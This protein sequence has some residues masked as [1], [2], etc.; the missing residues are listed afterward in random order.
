MP[1]YGGSGYDHIYLP[2]YLLKEGMY[3]SQAGRRNKYAQRAAA[4]RRIQ[5]GYRRYRRTTGNAD[6]R[7]LTS[8]LRSHRKA[9]PYQI[10]PSSG[11]TVTFWRKCEVNLT[12][13]QL[14]GFQLA[15]NNV[16]FGFSLR[17]VFGFINGVFAINTSVPNVSEFQALFDYYRISAV[18][19]QM[20]FTKNVSETSGLNIGLPVM[21]LANDFDDIAETMTRDSMNERV[22]CRHVQFSAYNENGINHYIKPKPDTVIVQTDPTTG[23]ESASNSGVVFGSQWIDTAQSN[24]VHNGIKVL[25]D[26]QGLTN[27]AALGNVSF[28]FD[29]CYDFK[30]YR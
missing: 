27:S 6:Q 11:R 19:L 3:G 14:T 21:L 2:K 24:I 4:A 25:Y 12:L 8:V 5:T 20:F 28:V 17:S 29:I 15:G 7:Q 22:G 23:V 13:N 26:S 18:K 30:G 9:C 10:T 1:Y 16:N